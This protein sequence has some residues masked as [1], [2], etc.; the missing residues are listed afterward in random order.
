[1]SKNKEKWKQNRT[2]LRDWKVV[3]ERLVV[4]GEFLLDLDWAKDWDNELEEMNE[5]KRGHPYEFPESLIEFQAVI[6]PMGKLQGHRGSN[7]KD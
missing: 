6:K 3:N 1:M 4:R 7:K 2:F 5:C